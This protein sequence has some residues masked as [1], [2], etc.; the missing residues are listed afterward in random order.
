MPPGEPNDVNVSSRLNSHHCCT[1]PG[2][3]DRR[4]TLEAPL[5]RLDGILG[6]EERR[7]C[8]QGYGI[9]AVAGTAN[10]H[11]TI[12]TCPI[13]PCWRA[14]SRCL[15]GEVGAFKRLGVARSGEVE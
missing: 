4:F 7:S 5:F 1:S 10:V 13:R 15:L 6:R 9:G 14:C 11:E 3:L 2:V 12:A 8:V